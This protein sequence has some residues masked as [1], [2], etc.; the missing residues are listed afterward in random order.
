M[1]PDSR[2]KDELIQLSVALKILVTAATWSPEN[3][4]GMREI[5]VTRESISKLV[6]SIL[7]FF[8]FPKGLIL[9]Q[10]VIFQKYSTAQVSQ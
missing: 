3:L 5:R 10:L 7:L 4:S 2:R 9:A 6:F 8:D 1:K